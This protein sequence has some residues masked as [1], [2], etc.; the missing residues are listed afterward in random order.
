MTPLIGNLFQCCLAKSRSSPLLIYGLL[1][2]FVES[3]QRKRMAS[4]NAKQSIGQNGSPH[5]LSEGFI[6]LRFSVWYSDEWNIWEQYKVML[7]MENSKR[8]SPL[9]ACNFGNSRVLWLKWD[10]PQTISIHRKLKKK[11]SYVEV[12]LA[13]SYQCSSCLSNIH[14][15]VKSRNGRTPQSCSPLHQFC[16]QWVL[17]IHKVKPHH[18]WDISN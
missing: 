14:P 16:H 7:F 9:L 10:F 12:V 11:R 6:Q 1:S 15:L 4:V 17:I 3:R 18:H 8:A 2:L 13:C 5:L